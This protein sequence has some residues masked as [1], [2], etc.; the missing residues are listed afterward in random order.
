MLRPTRRQYRE[1]AQVLDKMLSDNVNRD[2]FKGD[3]PLE[4]RIAAYDGTVE[5][6]QLGT[7]WEASRP[8]CERPLPPKQRPRA[9]NL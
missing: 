1:F 5:R 9:L 4:D 8:A 3:T 2:F 6:R 7:I